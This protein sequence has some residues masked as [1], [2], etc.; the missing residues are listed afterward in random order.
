MVENVIFV[1]ICI[2]FSIKKIIEISNIDFE[3]LQI[4]LL[5]YY[6]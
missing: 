5:I 6:L 1:K 2:L 4:E 3:Y